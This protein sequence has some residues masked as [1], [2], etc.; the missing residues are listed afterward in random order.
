MVVVVVGGGGGDA[1]VCHFVT[2]VRPAADVHAWQLPH[3]A[4]G[5]CMKTVSQYCP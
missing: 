5:V 3:R 2:D 1:S 4:L